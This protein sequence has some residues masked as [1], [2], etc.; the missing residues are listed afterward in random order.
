[1]LPAMAENGSWVARDLPVRGY[2]MRCWERPAAG[3]RVLFLHGFLDTGRSFAG[4]VEELPDEVHALCLDWRG[5]GGSRPVPEGMSFHQ[6]D[7]LKDLAQVVELL[8]PQR[9]VA[10]S[11][12]ATVAYLYAAAAPGRVPGYLMLDAAG[13]FASKPSDQAEALRKLLLAERQPKP[14]FRTF[15]SAEAAIERILHNN[16]GLSAEG[17]ARMVAGSTELTPQGEL[18]FLFDAR[19]RGPNPMRYSEAI[20]RELGRAITDPVVVLLGEKGLVRKAP[21]LR[22]RVEAMPTATLQMV[23]GVAH[24]LHLDAPAVVAAAV[25]AMLATTSG[26][27]AR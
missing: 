15:P 24:H 2:T 8:D 20:W 27:E 22:E 6:L 26:N 10:H 23:P 17:A 25:V 11:M 3:P 12:G 13:G 1:M 19:L 14:E 7:H 16:P 4:V 21:I 5:H 9:I 18:R